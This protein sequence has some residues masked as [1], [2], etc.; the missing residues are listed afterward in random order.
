MVGTSN[1]VKGRRLDP[2]QKRILVTIAT[3]LGV[4]V[5]VIALKLGVKWVGGDL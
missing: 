2:K 1:C 4:A 5:A 3:I